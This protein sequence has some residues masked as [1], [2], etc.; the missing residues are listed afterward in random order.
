MSVPIP[1]CFTEAE[2]RLAGMPG[3][4]E[5]TLSHLLM[6]GMGQP[7]PGGTPQEPLRAWQSLLVQGIP[8]HAALSC[9]SVCHSCLCRDR[10]S[11]SLVGASSQKHDIALC[12]PY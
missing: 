4:L 6:P 11:Q 9:L 8:G 3:D 7:S 5:D 12:V 2:P 10:P 1:T